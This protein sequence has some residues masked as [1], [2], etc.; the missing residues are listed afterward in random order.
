MT[1]ALAHKPVSDALVRL[2]IALL[3]LLAA[4]YFLMI[5]DKWDQLERA[6]Q[7]AERDRR[8][9]D[10]HADG[11]RKPPDQQLPVG[12]EVGKVVG[13]P[14]DDQSARLDRPFT[15]LHEV[16]RRAGP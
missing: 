10:R 3:A 5:K 1:D 4:G 15:Q 16:A 13:H 11:Y 12:G 2:L 14:A 7:Q 8:M 6:E 9:G